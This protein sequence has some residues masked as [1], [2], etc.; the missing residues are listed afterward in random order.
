MHDNNRVLEIIEPVVNDLGFEIV[1]VLLIGEKDLRLQVMVEPEDKRAMTVDDCANISRA[2]SAFLDV[3]DPIFG[4]Y[5]L[6]VSSPGLDRPL[7]RLSHFEEF[8]GL[9][10]RIEMIESIGGQKRFRGR[11]A[12]VSRGKVLMDVNGVARSFPPADIHRAKLIMNDEL[13][14]KAEGRN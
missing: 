12:G 8:I 9:E 5:T 4:S 6:E 10:A 14:A 11:L 13:L 3:E 7:V 2:V 1:R